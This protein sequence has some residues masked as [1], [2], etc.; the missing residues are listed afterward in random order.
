MRRLTNAHP[1]LAWSDKAKLISELNLFMW[2]AGHTWSYRKSMTEKIIAAYLKILDR[3]NS[4]QPMYRDRKT[5]QADRQKKT[6]RNWCKKL[7]YHT[8][9]PVQTTTKRQ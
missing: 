1:D 7:G 8:S 6:D 3:H 5:K 9:V 2:Q 4:G